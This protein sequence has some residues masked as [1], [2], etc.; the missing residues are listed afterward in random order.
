MTIHLGELLQEKNASD[1]NP[2]IIHGWN[3]YISPHED[4]PI[5][6]S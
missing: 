2:Q 4:D 6:V 5:H 3:K 1:D